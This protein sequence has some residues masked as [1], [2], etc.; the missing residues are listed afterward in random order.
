MA[1]VKDGRF[2]VICSVYQRVYHFISDLLV[3]RHF[4]LTKGLA[5]L[6]RKPQFPIHRLDY[7]R[8]AT[9]E[10]F[11]HEL[12][13]ADGAVAELGV[14]QGGF[15]RYIDQAFPARKF[16]LFDTFEGFD[17]RDVKR[18]QDKGFS[19]GS[20]RFDDTSVEMVLKQMKEP[21]RCIIRKGFFPDTFAG[22]ENERFSFVSLDADLYEPIHSGLV[23]FYPRLVQN[24]VI[25]IHDYNNSNYPGCREA[26]QDFCKK[27]CIPYVPVPDIGGTVVIRKANTC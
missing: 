14:Y 4:Y 9:L 19:D 26:V 17:Q 23:H 1:P 7:V 20:Q 18:E 15:A 6:G 22:L 27:S 16:Y 21:G 11:A 13:S 12:Q 2:F 25:M 5:F 24:G 3:R 8:I 10:L